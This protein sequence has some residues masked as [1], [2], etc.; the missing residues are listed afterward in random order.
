MNIPEM[1]EHVDMAMRMDPFLP[2]KCA[3]VQLKRLIVEPIKLLSTLPQSRIIIIDGLDECDGLDSQ[4]DVLSLVAEV[5][6]DPNV[7]IRFIIASRPEDPMCRS[8]KEEP[9]LSMTRPLILDKEY[10]HTNEFEEASAPLRLGQTVT[11]LIFPM[12]SRSRNQKLAN[13]RSTAGSSQPPFVLKIIEGGTFTNVSGDSIYH[14]HMRGKFE[15]QS[16]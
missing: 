14:Q 8:F 12:S 9:L 7:P 5:A 13:K 10:D 1:Y 4:S 6:R 11:T 15:V 2:K 3:D 16:L